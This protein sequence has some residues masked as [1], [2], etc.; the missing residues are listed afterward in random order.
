MEFL[1][2][3]EFWEEKKWPYLFQVCQENKGLPTVYMKKISGSQHLQARGWE[4]VRPRRPELGP[5]APREAAGQEGRSMKGKGQTGPSSQPQHFLQE[6]C[7]PRPWNVGGPSCV[8]GEVNSH[9]PPSPHCRLGALLLEALGC[10]VQPHSS[11][12]LSSEERPRAQSSA[13]IR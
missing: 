7:G 13:E 12:A 8:E 10:L 1:A 5:Q 11:A 9:L 6:E 3:F 2:F 4:S